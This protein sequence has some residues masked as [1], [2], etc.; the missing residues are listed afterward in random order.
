M[1]PLRVLKAFAWLRWRMFVNALERTGSRDT[2]ER[3]SLAI[4]R[5]GPILAAILLVPSALMLFGL[6]IYAGYLLP[7]DD[8]NVPFTTV[9]FILLAVPLL[10]VAGPLFFPA[11]DRTNPTRLLLLPIPRSTLYA[12]QAAGAFGDPWNLLLVPLLAGIATGLAVAGAL[13]PSPVS[14]PRRCWWR[15]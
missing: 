9:R 8:S 10:A 11:A 1:T 12:A 4:E 14:R 6:G 7:G 5:L 2:L 13:P 15:W 3:F